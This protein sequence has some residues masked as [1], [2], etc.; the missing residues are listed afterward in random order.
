M[1]GGAQPYEIIRRPI[2]GES[3]SIS[4]SRLANQAQIRVLL[5]DTQADLHMPDWNGDAT[6]DVALDNTTAGS[7][8]TGVGV[9]VPGSRWWQQHL[10]CHRK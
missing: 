8:Y 9:P 2:A 4:G 1:G 7:V 5:S 3:T 6:Q 10:L